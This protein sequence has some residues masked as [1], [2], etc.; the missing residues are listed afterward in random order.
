MLPGSLE[1]R[2]GGTIYDRRIVEGLR[3]RGYDIDVAELSGS[4][5]FPHDA[6]RKEASDRLA[7]VPD[8]A[9]VIIDGLAF[10]AL[11]GLA[12]RERG[13]L[14]M[15]ALVHHPLADETGLSGAQCAALKESEEEALEHARR[16]IVTSQFTRSRLASYRVPPERIRVVLPGTDPAALAERNLERD[17]VLLCPAA[18]IPR[19]G[20]R[21]LLRALA[22]LAAI[23]WR[24]ICAG[25]ED[26][27]S[28]CAADIRAMAADLGLAS[29]VTFCGEVGA[30][31]MARLYAEAD[32]LVLA[33]QYEGY[34]MVVS[35]A[36]ARGLPVVTTTGGALAYTLPEGAGLACDAGD[37]RAFSENLRR[38]LTDRMLYERLAMGARAAR[39]TLPKWEDAASEFEAALS[40]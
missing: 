24:L 20:H 31:A 27:D 16:V 40:A 21:D 19:K 18:L 22:P 33:S 35:E 39:N 5:P 1:R 8:G 13:R 2:T 3:A 36:I 28:A 11:P 23:P 4:Y 37:V 34:G 30:D 7:A 15:I 17:L 26:S 6:A 12:Q 10:G 14:N 32:L 38:V 25:K 29:R 9:T